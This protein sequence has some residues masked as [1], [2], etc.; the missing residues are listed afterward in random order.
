[1]QRIRFAALEREPVQVE[2]V[3][4]FGIRCIYG[5]P[6]R[7]EV[8]RAAGAERARETV[9]VAMDEMEEASASSRSPGATSPNCG[10]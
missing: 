6:A 5:D 2:V 8:L 9:V 10:S 4:R 7:P 3:R 1:M